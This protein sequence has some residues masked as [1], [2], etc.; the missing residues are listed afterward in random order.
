MTKSIRPLTLTANIL[1]VICYEFDM[2]AAQ[3][4][5]G[6]LDNSLVAEWRYC[7]TVFYDTE[8]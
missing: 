1:S 5:R 7:M 6:R 2:V 3:N 4:F 8:K